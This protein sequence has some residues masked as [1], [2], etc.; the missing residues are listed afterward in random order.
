MPRSQREAGFKLLELIVAMG[1][2]AT[3]IGFSMQVVLRLQRN[4]AGQRTQARGE[5]AIEMMLSA[6]RRDILW[7]GVA[8]LQRTRV[9]PLPV[10]GFEP[11]AP[12]RGGRG[13]AVPAADGEHGALCVHPFPRPRSP[14]HCSRSK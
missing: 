5:V 7:A 8:A 10:G 2:M 13:T 14:R 3:F 6:L 1:L 4:A 12:A 11:R 9:H